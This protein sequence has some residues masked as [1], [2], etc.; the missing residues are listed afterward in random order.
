MKKILKKS[1]KRGYKKT[2]NILKY[3]IPN[4]KLNLPNGTSKITGITDINEI[5]EIENKQINLINE[6]IKKQITKLKLKNV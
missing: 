5:V 6:V 4:L 2:Y 3:I 1:H